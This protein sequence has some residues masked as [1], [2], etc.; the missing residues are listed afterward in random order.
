MLTMFVNCDRITIHIIEQI[1]NKEVNYMTNAVYV[2]D[3]F[4]ERLVSD[5][6]KKENQ[7]NNGPQITEEFIKEQV[8]SYS[9]LLDSKFVERAL[10]K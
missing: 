7:P 1:V 3:N 5:G 8:L 6:Y 2:M 9:K 4:M 10:G